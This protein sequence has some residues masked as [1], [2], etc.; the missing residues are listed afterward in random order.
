[1][2]KILRIKYLFIGWIEYMKRPMLAKKKIE[3]C[4]PFIVRL[5]KTNRRCV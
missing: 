5:L 1:M 2:V 3:Q 4:Y